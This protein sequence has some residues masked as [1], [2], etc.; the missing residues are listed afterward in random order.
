MT[1]AEHL[2][3]LARVEG[4]AREGLGL[5]RVVLEDLAVALEQL[6]QARCVLEGAVAASVTPEPAVLATG[7]CGR[8]MSSGPSGQLDAPRSCGLVVEQGPNGRPVVDRP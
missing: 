7:A 8:L 5:A 2:T 6:H 4:D 3:L 1:L